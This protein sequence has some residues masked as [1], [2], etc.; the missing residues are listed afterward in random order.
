MNNVI[1]LFKPGVCQLAQENALRVM[2]HTWT[3]LGPETKKFEDEFADY[4]GTKYA[5]GT[6]NCTTALEMAIHALDLPAGSLAATTALTFISTPHAIKKSNLN[7]IYVDVNTADG[8]MNMYDLERLLEKG[9]NIKLVV[10]VHYMGNPVD[11]DMLLKLK[12]KYGFYVI[13]DCAHTPGA[14]YQRG[15]I[16]AHVGS[17]SDMGCFSFHSLKPLSAGDGGAI[18][19]DDPTLFETLSKLRWFNALSTHD[20]EKEERYSWDYGITGPGFKGYMNDIVAAIARG[21]LTQIK[22]EAATRRNQLGMYRAQL[23]ERLMTPLRQGAWTAAHLCVCKLVASD[24]RQE[25]I[26][27]MSDHK[28]HIGVHYRPTSYYGYVSGDIPRSL[29]NTVV[30]YGSIISLPIH[31]NHSLKDIKRVIKTINKGGWL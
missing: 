6:N 12:K 27:F 5:V 4:V 26:K 24:K 1:H 13:E 7:L 29:S 15:N 19:T 14:F 10:P 2:Q 28:I 17:E 22:V 23:D 20:R 30:L 3:T 16:K 8:S 9:Y 25:F 11:M 18:T 21:Q 31:H